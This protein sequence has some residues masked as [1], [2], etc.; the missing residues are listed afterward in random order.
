MSAPTLTETG[1]VQA[2]SPGNK[3]ERRSSVI[4]EEK[5][6][7][8]GWVDDLE[9]F[10]RWAHSDEFPE[11]GWFSYLNGKIWADLSRE[12]L[13]SHNQVK[14][15]FTFAI[16]ALLEQIPTGRFVLD[17]MLLSNAAANLSTEPDGLFFLWDT[18]K[19]GRLR[20][21]EGSVQGYVELE[22]TPDMVLEVI[23]RSSVRK[24]TERLRE[25]YWR[26]GISEYWLVDARGT[27]LRFDIFRHTKEGYV[28]TEPHDGW[29]RS[30]VFGHAFQLIRLTDAVGLPQFKVQARST[31]QTTANS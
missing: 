20:L 12:E 10:R 5:V 28:A 21:I 14:G 1:A 4:I 3:P 19:S 9:S 17:R 26:A 30:N 24:D 8:P 13:F 22:G 31:A 15:T 29:L 27:S 7:I 6:C 25:L 11:R 2:P 16:L 18:L 23:S